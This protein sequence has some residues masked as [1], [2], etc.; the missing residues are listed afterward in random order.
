M[1]GVN[2]EKFISDQL[3]VW[4]LA[5]SNYRSL[6][7]VQTREIE[8][9]G[10]S[11]KL[12]H[13]PDR[14]R[15][16]AAKIDSSSLKTRSC[17][18]C[19]ENRPKE[20]KYLKFEGRKGRSYQILLNPYPIFPAHLV[21]ASDTH[22][23]Q[24][25]W[26]RYVDMMDLAHH[27]PSYTFFYNGPECGASAPDHLHFQACPRMSLPLE[28]DVD[29]L[30]DL[31]PP[32]QENIVVPR[33]EEL[34]YVPADIASEIEY[35]DSVQE[36]QLFHYKH[37]TKGVFVLRARTSK[38]MAKLFYRLMDCASV[39]AETKEPKINVL[40]WY[41]TL[42]AGEERPA[43]NTHGLAPFEYRAVVLFRDKHRP[44]HFYADGESHLTI[45]PGCA[46][47][48]GLFILPHSEDY[49]KMNPSLA[50][51][52]MKEVSISEQEEKELLWRLTRGQET[53]Q[54][55]IMSGKEIEF[56]IITD[57]AGVQKV[58][59]D[60]GRISYGGVLY[61]EL[62]FDAGTMSTLFAEPSFILYGVTI[63]IDFH[64]E[65]KQVQKFAGS[66]KF[67]VEGEKIVAVNIVGVE[68]YL[69][70]VISSEMKSSAT[71]E[72]LKAHAVISRSWV[73]SQIEN[74]AKSQKG[75]KMQSKLEADSIAEMS[76]R[77]GDPCI[78]K[79]FDHEDHVNFD[80]CADDH[81]QR[82]QG[83]T[84][85]VGQNVR[86]AIDATWGQVLMYDGEICDARFSKCCGGVSELFSSCWSDQDKDYLQA[87]PDTDGHESGQHSYC[88]TADESIL[89]QVLNDYDMETKDFYRWSQEYDKAYLSEL[90]KR[91]SGHDI[92]QIEDIQALKISPSGRIIELK[93][94]GTK[95][96][97][98]IGKELMIR[99]ILS[100]THLKSSAFTAEFSDNKVI[101][102][103]RGW[104]HG[105]GLCQIG[106]AVMAYQGHTYENILQH[107]YPNSELKRR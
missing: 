107:Y 44:H 104:G 18:L 43:G 54:V 83:L 33:G 15:S 89:S 57:G 55:G 1:K 81:C 16:T 2:I 11:I 67:I 28:E 77:N 94:I 14:I 96:N 25:I 50:A 31:I 64:W 30:L 75:N 95:S 91:K 48:A 37:F 76:V 102:R 68:D 62:Y 60:N 21:I 70:S 105:V 17:F 73:M 27:F 93:L 53:I 52:V 5:S 19:A 46:D 87:L 24:T 20:Q 36:A 4:T 56:E 42:E 47:M 3:S 65:R 98:I 103:G 61:D 10:L 41:K 92:G 59:Y 63:G 49:H 90:I 97:L 99:K 6:K 38:S 40:T 101:L 8:L 88:D 13:N 23:D 85:A 80:V 32:T 82:Y 51:E 34:A 86:K 106:A 71:L 29:R 7:S 39:K 69:L 79:W 78:I 66:L 58:S 45:S 26:H 22:E 72:Y 35:I 74:R 84:M 9:N 12:Q 100:E